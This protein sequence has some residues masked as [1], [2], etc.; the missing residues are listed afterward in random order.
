MFRAFLFLA[1]IT[2]AAGSAPAQELDGRLKQIYETGIDQAR[3]PVGRKSVLLHLSARAT[4]WLY[5]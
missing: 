5:N 3:L 1:A 4:G 2:C